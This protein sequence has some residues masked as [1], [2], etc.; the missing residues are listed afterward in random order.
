MPNSLTS[1]LKIVML[2]MMISYGAP[3]L[4]A[5]FSGTWILD[6]SAS[7]SVEPLLKARGVSMVK[8][9]A[10]ASMSVTRIISQSG[11]SMTVNTVTSAKNETKTY[12]VDGQTR[13]V[14]GDQGSADISHRWDG[15]V[16]ITTA[17]SAEGTMTTR[18]TISA[19]GRTLTEQLTY[20]GS[21]GSPI[22]VNRIYT[23]Q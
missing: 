16:M 10:A 23:K 11:N 17:Q 9:K 8:R 12:Q 1:L 14:S 6:L 15:E 5:D 4:A 19:D 22:V 21:D 18:R 7:D 2:S 20:K 13:T 3:A